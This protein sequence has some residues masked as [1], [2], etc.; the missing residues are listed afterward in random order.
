M[1][2]QIPYFFASEV[3]IGGITLPVHGLAICAGAILAYAL[4][5]TQSRRIGLPIGLLVDTIPFISI[6]TIV[7]GHAP[8]WLSEGPLNQS[9]W[10]GQSFTTSMLAG[11]LAAALAVW[12]AQPPSSRSMS[13]GLQ[14]INVLALASLG[15]GAI[16]R[17]GCLFSHEHIG[18]ATMMWTGIRGL[19]TGGAAAHDLSLY[20]IT[21][22]ACLATA[23]FKYCNTQRGNLAI[24]PICLVFYAALP[25]IHDTLLPAAVNSANPHSI[26]ISLRP[27]LLIACA[28]MVLVA[29]IAPSLI[30]RFRQNYPHEIPIDKVT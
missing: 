30:R 14:Y 4:A 2:A 3:C 26:Q 5:F 23:L 8:F 21:V 13:T 7:G 18:G 9:L 16:A 10:N 28:S 12:F 17:V 20:D 15:G 19:G 25:V 27:V 24:L 22:A 1:S 29:A 6:F 11:F